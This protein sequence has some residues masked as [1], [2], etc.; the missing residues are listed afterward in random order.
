MKKAYVHYFDSDASYF[1]IAADDRH[2]DGQC[3]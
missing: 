3:A 1:I 2:H